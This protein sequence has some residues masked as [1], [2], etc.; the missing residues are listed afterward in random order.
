MFF[1]QLEIFST[2]S[3]INLCK[4]PGLTSSKIFLQTIGSSILFFILI[5][6]SASVLCVAFSLTKKM[7]DSNF[8][9]RGFT[10]GSRCNL[11]MYSCLDE[12]SLEYVDSSSKHLS[13]FLSFLK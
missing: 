5:I 4:I 3:G 10:E 12:F 7:F 2:F 6:A 11:M 13:V 1:K 8:L 9:S